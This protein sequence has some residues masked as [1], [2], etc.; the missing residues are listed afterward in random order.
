MALHRIQ[1]GQQQELA[2]RVLL[3]QARAG[4]RLAFETLVLRYQSLLY[5][6]ARHYLDAEQASDIVQ[7]VMLQLY[8]SLIKTQGNSFAGAREIALKPWLLRV[9]RNRCID[10]W[11]RSKR[12]PLTFSEL[13]QSGEAEIDALEA[14]L[15]PAPLPE[16]Y[17]EQREKQDAI[18]T[19]IQ[20]LPLKFRMVVW[21]RYTEDLSFHEIG[22]RLY[23]LPTTAKTYYYRAR[24]QL[25]TALW[26]QS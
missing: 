3:E 14:L 12:R 9:T 11:R 7:A 25:R 2:D 13:E 8:L 4:D 15:D 17:T 22:E 1:Q 20:L 5:G 18:R 26:I 23:M 16:V 6:I 19:A 24:L 10:E 21:L